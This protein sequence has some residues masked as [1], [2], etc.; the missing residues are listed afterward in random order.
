MPDLS[1][2]WVLIEF[3]CA[4]HLH[5]NLVSVSNDAR[6]QKGYTL[7]LHCDLRE[8]QTELEV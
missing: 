4:D 7:S 2:S 1:A 8:T 3:A 5:D 6:L